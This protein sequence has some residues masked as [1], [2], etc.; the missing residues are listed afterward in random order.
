MKLS[1]LWLSRKFSSMELKLTQLF[2]KVGKHL[3]FHFNF[4]II[5]YFCYFICRLVFQQFFGKRPQ[6]FPKLGIRVAFH[7]NFP[8]CSHFW[9]IL[10]PIIFQQIPKN[11][12]KP[13]SFPKLCLTP[14]FIPQWENRFFSCDHGPLGGSQTL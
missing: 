12:K 2:P 7:F 5:S 1:S 11:V 13:N 10:I 4:P 14:N 6:L 9:E 8:K 3:S